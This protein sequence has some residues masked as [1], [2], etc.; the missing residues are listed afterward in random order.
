M[1]SNKDIMDNLCRLYLT[2]G[3]KTFIIFDA[4]EDYMMNKCVR[5]RGIM[6]NLIKLSDSL[7][8][9][10]EALQQEKET[11]REKNELLKLEVHRLQEENRRKDALL[12]KHSTKIG[13]KA[14]YKSEASCELI[15][16][17]LKMGK[18]KAQIAREL[19]V[20]R[21]LVYSRIKELQSIGIDMSKYIN[22]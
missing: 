20:D 21:S 5:I 15:F 18:S 9:K 22:K 7:C 19:G 16:Q 4:E 10:C 3:A 8:D 6:E 17:Q 13:N 2:L 12:N 11:L 14:A 1:M